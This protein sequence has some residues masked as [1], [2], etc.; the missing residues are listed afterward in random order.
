VTRISLGQAITAVEW[1]LLAVFTALLSVHTLPH[2]WRTLNTDFPNYY[3]AAQ[4]AHEGYDMSQAYDW[5]WFQREKDHH[6]IDQPIVGLVPITPFSTLF[7]WPLTNLPPLKAKRAWLLSQ[8]AL[9]IPIALML[10]SLTHLPSRRIALLT[11]ACLP[12]HRNLLY[13][14]F[15]ILLLAMLVA[16]CW[17]YRR[18]LSVLAGVLVGLATLTKIFPIIFMLYFLRKQ[19]WRAILAAVVTV[20]AGVL[21]SISIFGWSLH[22]EYLQVILPWTLRG[23][24]LPPYT[25]A[26]S[27]LPALLHRLFVYEPQWNPHPWH[28]EPI[29][30]AVLVPIIQAALIAPAI[31]FMRDGKADVSDRKGDV[32]LEWSALLCATLA[33]STSPA[34]YNFV[35]L[36]LPMTV[37]CARLLPRKPVLAFIALLLYF[38]IGY[39]N[40]NTTSVDGLRAVLHVPRLWFLIAFSFLCCWVMAHASIRIRWR[41][42]HNLLWAGGFAALAAVGIV[43]GIRHQRNLYEDNAYRLPMQPDVLLA[44]SPLSDNGRIEAVAMLPGGYQVL[45]IAPADSHVSPELHHRMD[46]LS[47][48]VSHEGDWI[49]EVSDHSRI[50]SSRSLTAVI[51]AAHTPFLAPDQQI[52]AYIVDHQG[53]G[54]LVVQ[55]LEHAVDRATAITPDGINVSEAAVLD[56]NSFFIAA[57]SE[58]NPSQIFFIQTN[59]A[60][61]AMNLGEARY[62]SLSPDRRW[63]AYSRFQSGVWNLWLFDRT[64]QQAHRLSTVPCN[65]VEPSWEPDSKILLYASDCGRSLGFTA[66]CRRKVL[67]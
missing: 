22:R 9:L 19:D 44:A 43:S 52:L 35:L 42:A 50:V 66:I 13:G 20:G 60:P 63:L 3:L 61:K 2:A 8:L 53:R 51:D 21:A 65:Q 5:R 25:L 18:R 47:F 10:Q 28:N 31:L 59:A 49:E 17:T 7:I 29:V 55:S 26:S 36:I 15:Y 27:S 4:L 30:V 32:P 23:E 67:P 33:T 58:D 14:Q 40:W 41:Q 54:R 39:P 1:L 64:M 34:S 16:A 12:L 24:V 38:A 48:T 11:V 46:Q 45:P 56:R 62:P 37:L 57:T 6:C